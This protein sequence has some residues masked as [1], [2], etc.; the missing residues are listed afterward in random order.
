MRLSKQWREKIVQEFL[1]KLDFLKSYGFE[2]HEKSISSFGIT[3]E[4]INDNYSIEISTDFFN[5]TS[6]GEGYSFGI[7]KKSTFFEK[8]KGI[9]YGKGFGIYDLK[10]DSIKLLTDLQPYLNEKN[11]S[12]VIDLTVEYIKKY[13]LPIIKDNKWFDDSFK[14]SR[15]SR[16]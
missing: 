15:D 1:D 12:L 3:I 5:G 8:K 4:Y 9:F 16:F 10:Y 7:S 11:Y 6:L 13:F 2:V 14:P